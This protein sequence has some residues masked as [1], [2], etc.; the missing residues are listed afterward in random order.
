MAIFCFFFTLTLHVEISFFL[1]NR[2]RFLQEIFCRKRN[3]LSVRWAIS[4]FRDIGSCVK[5]D[6]FAFKIRYLEDK[7]SYLI[8][9]K[10]KLKL[11]KQAMRPMYWSSSKK[12]FHARRAKEKKEKIWKIFSLWFIQELHSYRCSKKILTKK[13]ENQN[14]QASKAIFLIS[15]TAIFD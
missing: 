8:P 15:C 1:I 11:N 4:N 14:L 13:F 6:H 5:K 9:A 3:P 10:S 12:F 2:D 7:W